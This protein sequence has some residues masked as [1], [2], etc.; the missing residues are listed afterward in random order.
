MWCRILEY[1]VETGL[2]FEDQMSIQGYKTRIEGRR[3]FAY[4]LEDPLVF[5][6]YQAESM[7]G[8]AKVLIAGY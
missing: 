3:Q 8:S 6:E 7:H 4:I 5:S 2:W 1:G